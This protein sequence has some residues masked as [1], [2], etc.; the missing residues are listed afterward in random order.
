[1]YINLQV[2]GHKI[3]LACSNRQ[4][5]LARGM[6]RCYRVEH[7]PRIWGCLPLKGMGI[8]ISFSH[9]WKPNIVSF[10]GSNNAEHKKDRGIPHYWKYNGW[11][12]FS[13]V[14]RYIH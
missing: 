8:E 9:R 1:M 14:D 6:L 13:T 2:N 12:S 11:A 10:L 3:N 5:G 4:C 7:K